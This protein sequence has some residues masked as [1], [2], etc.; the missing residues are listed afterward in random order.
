[1]SLKWIER[2]EKLREVFDSE[3]NYAQYRKLPKDAPCIPFL[4][5]SLKDLL[6]SYEGNPD[7]TDGGINFLKMRR[8]MEIIRTLKIEDPSQ[9][10]YHQLHFDAQVSQALLSVRT[11][12]SLN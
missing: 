2:F 8:I 12:P 9:I 5:V 11:F 7:E 4:G 1:M 10:D 6:Y 3:G